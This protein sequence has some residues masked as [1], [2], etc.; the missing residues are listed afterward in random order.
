LSPAL[1]MHIPF[2]LSKLRQT[3]PAMVM[4]WRLAVRQVLQEAFAH[5]Y[6]VADFVEDGNHCAYVLTPPKAYFLYVVQC[7]DQTLYTGIASNVRARVKAHNAGRGASYT[8]A[9]RPVQLLAAWRFPD[10]G[11][12]LKAEAAFKQLS[13]QEK[14]DYVSLKKPYHHMSFLEVE[15]LL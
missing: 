11:S 4:P 6:V 12:A 9:R 15:S 8:R 14:L 5:G 1:F 10:R 13:R 7:S 2:H 3:N